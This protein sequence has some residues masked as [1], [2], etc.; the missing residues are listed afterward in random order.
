MDFGP[1]LR[2]LA[3]QRR[4][5]LL[6]GVP[7][8]AL[9]PVVAPLA[10]LLAQPCSARLQEELLVEVRQ[11]FPDGVWLAWQV[12]ARCRQDVGRLLS[13]EFGLQL[14]AGPVFVVFLALLELLVLGVA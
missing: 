4:V 10:L 11:R 12:A 13:C 8:A 2:L 5:A 1:Q 9:T 7:L 3:L 6:A 14:L